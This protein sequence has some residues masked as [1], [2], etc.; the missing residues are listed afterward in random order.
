M[1]RLEQLLAARGLEGGCVAGG[2]ALGT[3]RLPPAHNP[4][5][6]RSSSLRAGPH[7]LGSTGL[8]PP[9]V[10]LPLGSKL[11]ANQEE[12]GGGE[13]SS[14]PPDLFPPDPL[15]GFMPPPNPEEAERTQ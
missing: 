10:V 11:G 14:A 3:L 6:H 15:L 2:D 8:S 7:T 12:P 13:P 5:T 1:A 4:E 9:S